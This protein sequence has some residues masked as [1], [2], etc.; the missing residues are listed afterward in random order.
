[1]RERPDRVL[2]LFVDG[3]GL[4]ES[5]LLDS[6]YSRCPALLRLF[7]DACVPLDPSLGVPG[8]P[9]SATGQTALL[10]TEALAKAYVDSRAQPIYAG[11]NEI[12]KEIIGRAMG[13]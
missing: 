10:Y 12:M 5:P 9:Q 11:T 6:V 3:L 8:T 2:M 4:P 7:A 1:M 13:F